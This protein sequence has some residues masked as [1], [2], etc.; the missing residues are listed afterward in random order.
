MTTTQQNH[1]QEPSTAKRNLYQNAYRQTLEE[2]V[3]TQTNEPVNDTTSETDPTSPEEKSW[4][5]R[6][7]DLRSFNSN[8]TDRVKLLENQ[9]E[10]VQ[11]KE[12][13]IPSTPEELEGFSRQF[14]DVYRHIKSIAMGE[15]LQ[16]KEDITKQIEVE[17]EKLEKIERES[18]FKKILQVHPDFEDLNMS[19]QFH[20]WAAQ[21]PKQIQD[22][23]FE[24]TDPTLCIK[25]LDLYKAEHNFKK[26]KTERKP[27]GADS[28]V[29]T[30]TTPE[31][32][33]DG[34]KKIW[35]ESD[36]GRL[37]P[38]DYEKV[39]SEIELARAEGRIEYGV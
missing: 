20:E 33:S 24:S 26:Q 36:I 5:K 39:E 4:K 29:R 3:A 12:I 6:Y 11:R 10:Q 22:W 19:E 34:N 35:K 7:S 17:K 25:A 27:S 8:L 16:Q 18:G 28:Q 15:V 37:K 32:P 31:I 1:I 9:L 2:D 14:P 38:R 30:R 13:K 21:Q 23:L